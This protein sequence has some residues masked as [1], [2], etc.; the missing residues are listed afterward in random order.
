MLLRFIN[1]TNV[2]FLI[3]IRYIFQGVLSG[4]HAEAKSLHT[5]P[6]TLRVLLYVKCSDYV[7]E[8]VIQYTI[9]MLL[10]FN[11]KC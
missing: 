8:Q 1:P 6:S 11:A 4:M 5:E 7:S 2:D 10:R 3:K 9:R